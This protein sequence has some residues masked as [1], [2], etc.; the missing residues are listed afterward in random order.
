MVNSRIVLGHIASEKGM[1]LDKTKVELISKLPPLKTV[2][3]VWSFLSHVGFYR[4]FIKNLSKIFKP[5]CDFLVKDVSFEFNLFCLATFEKLK[6]EFTSAPIIQP[7]DW[8]LP[9]EMMCDASDYVIEVVLD[10]RVD[11]LPHVNCYASKTLNDTQLN[12]STTEKELLAIIFAFDKF[13][14]YLKGSKVLIYTDHVALKYLLT[15]K[16]AK[17]RLIRWILLLQEFDLEIHDNK[18]R[19]ENVVADHLSRLVVG[20]SSDLL[21]VL[22]T[23]LDEQLMSIS[24]TTVPWYADIVNYLVT[25]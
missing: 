24:L 19:A 15:K 18:K 21:P 13:H 22:E 10:Q 17:A 14:L 20:F 11:K 23:F 4:R 1:E 2:Q 6:T 12:Y 3:E 9:F 8:N 25:E 7:P 5:L 16:D